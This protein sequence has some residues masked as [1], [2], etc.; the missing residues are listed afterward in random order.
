MPLWKERTPITAQPSELD[1]HAFAG[2]LDHGHSPSKTAPYH[3]NLEACIENR[4]SKE[5]FYR[6]PPE[7][8]YP[9]VIFFKTV[10][11]LT[12]LGRFPSALKF[13]RL[14]FYIFWKKNSSFENIYRQNFSCLVLALTL[15]GLF[16]S[17]SVRFVPIISECALA[18]RQAVYVHFD[19]LS[20][21]W[22]DWEYWMLIL[23]RFLG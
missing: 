3:R 20:F 10:L 17:W 13:P 21:C 22:V 16:P 4:I 15:A 11:L 18:E 1:K 2:S 6:R 9:K 8:R 23:S 14:I 19:T 7:L 5:Q 12:G